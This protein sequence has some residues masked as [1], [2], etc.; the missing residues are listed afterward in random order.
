MP[1]DPGLPVVSELPPAP[2]E[3]VV[4]PVMSVPLEVPVVLVLSPVWESPPLPS[5]QAM[6]NNAQQ[7]RIE[8]VKVLICFSVPSRS[9]TCRQLNC[10]DSV[11]LPCDDSSQ[12]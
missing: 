1:P 3:P 5:L 6:P 11:I 8:V 2:G 9:K 12:K 7:E 4:E 10:A